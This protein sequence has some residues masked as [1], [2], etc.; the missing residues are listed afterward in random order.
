MVQVKQKADTMDTL[1]ISNLKILR[2]NK[3]VHPFVI[4]QDRTH[5]IR[6]FYWMTETKTNTVRHSLRAMR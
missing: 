3:K 4:I 1:D 6:R 5:E 2:H